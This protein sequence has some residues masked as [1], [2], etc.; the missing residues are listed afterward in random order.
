MKT[1]HT[2][3]CPVFALH[4]ALAGNK[5]IPQWNSRA[6]IG[7]NLG[8]S[9]MH[10]CNVHL[11]LSLITGLMCLQFYCRV[12]GFF[13]TCKYGFSDIGISSM[14]QHLAE[15]KHA[16]EDPWIQSDQ[17]LLSCAPISKTDNSTKSRLPTSNISFFPTES[18]EE[19][20]FSLEFF[21]DGGIN[22]PDTKE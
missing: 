15:L 7:L 16:Y 4:H 6:H 13:E 17:R 3:G 8:P 14:W 11:V 19:Q 21:K 1:L 10:A 5:S 22:I 2:F 12:D 20:S 18:H 9:P